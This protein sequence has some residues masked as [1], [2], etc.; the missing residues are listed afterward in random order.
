M[1]KLYTLFFNKLRI[2][3]W[4][5]VPINVD[6]VLKI[7][8]K[9]E[10][11][12]CYL[13]KLLKTLDQNIPRIYIDCGANLGL[14]SSAIVDTIGESSTLISFEPRIDVF[15]ILKERFKSYSNFTGEILAVSNNNKTTYLC[16]NS[17]FAKGSLSFTNRDYGFKSQPVYSV[18]LDSYIQNIKHNNNIFFIKI[19]VEGHELNVLKGSEIILKNHKPIILC[20]IEQ[21]HHGSVSSITTIFKYM[22]NLG[23]CAY[24]YSSNKE[25][26]VSVDNIFSNQDI[27][28]DDYIFNYWFVH[29]TKLKFLPV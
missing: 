21:R 20:E 13:K 4:K 23:Y 22:K 26:L 19:D 25:S 10:K 12:I 28:S 6:K 1:N 5:I 3:K 9:K 8:Q 17:S 27:N 14:Y 29:Q 11:D 24:Y 2:L 16:L 18:R 7:E 15:I